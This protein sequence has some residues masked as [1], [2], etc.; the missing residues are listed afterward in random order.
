VTN[1]SFL[2][3][4]LMGDAASLRVTGPTESSL[5]EPTGIG[6]IAIFRIRPIAAPTTK[7]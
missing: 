4:D 6:G 1:E 3:D 7:S 5:P 2:G